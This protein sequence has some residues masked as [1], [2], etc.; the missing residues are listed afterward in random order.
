MGP[1]KYDFVQCIVWDQDQ[2]GY[3]TCY[4]TFFR[5]SI[6]IL[7]GLKA[8]SLVRKYVFQRPEL[9]GKWRSHGTEIRFLKLKTEMYQWIELKEYMGRMGS[10]V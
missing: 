1:Q 4:Q 5:K 3:K 8:S 7:T 2:T 9:T 6:L 10:F